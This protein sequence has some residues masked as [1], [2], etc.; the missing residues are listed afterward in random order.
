[1]GKYYYKVGITRAS[2]YY[3]VENG[4]VQSGTTLLQSGAVLQ[5]RAIQVSVQ[6]F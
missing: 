5:S 3:K 2:R 1:M 6:K 4:L